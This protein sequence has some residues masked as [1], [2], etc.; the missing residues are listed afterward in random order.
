MPGTD[1]RASAPAE[2][3]AVLE[4]IVVYAEKLVIGLQS[5]RADRED[6]N[7]PQEQEAP[8]AL[9]RQLVGIRPA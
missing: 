6:N 2:E 7:L 3:E 1:S 8:S 4:E 9:P 5:V